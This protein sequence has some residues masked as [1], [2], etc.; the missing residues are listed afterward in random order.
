[1]MCNRISAYECICEYDLYSKVLRVV[2]RI[3]KELL[4]YNPFTI[5]S[6]SIHKLCLTQVKFV[7]INF[8]ISELFYSFFLFNLFAWLFY[9]ACLI[10]P[11]FI[12]TPCVR[13][14]ALRV[15]SSRNHCVS[16]NDNCSVVPRPQTPTAGLINRDPN[17]RD[18][19]HESTCLDITQRTRTAG[20][21]QLALT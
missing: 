14:Q 2:N 6:F 20:H 19:A 9:F 4:K 1:M 11:I 13:P 12:P 5:K 7:T 3:R 15:P 10:S 16:V 18:E 8:V 17:R 21:I